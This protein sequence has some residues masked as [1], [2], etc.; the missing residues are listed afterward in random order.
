MVLDLSLQPM[1]EPITQRIPVR[2]VVCF[3]QLPTLLGFLEVDGSL[4]QFTRIIS[5]QSKI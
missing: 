1:T 5:V 4:D 2:L 3:K